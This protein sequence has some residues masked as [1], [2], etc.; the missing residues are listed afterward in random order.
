MIF[1]AA[2]AAYFIISAV[3]ILSVCVLSARM[4]QREDWS[5]VPLAENRA[6]ANA[7]RDYQADV[8]TS[9]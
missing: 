6:E 9:T 3:V 1:L 8:A 7:A 5:E 2:I 4:S